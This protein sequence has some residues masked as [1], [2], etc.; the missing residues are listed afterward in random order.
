M[1][2]VAIN[3]L[4]R[5][6]RAALKLLVESDDLDLVAVNDLADAENLAYL[7][8][9]D[10]VYGRYQSVVRSEANTL[11]IDGQRIPVSPKPIRRTCRGASSGSTSYSSAPARSGASRT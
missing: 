4:G 1:N 5:I 11:L 10:T 6:G 8:N 9:Y 2:R 3:G 7:I